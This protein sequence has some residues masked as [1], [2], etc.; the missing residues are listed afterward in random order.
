MIFLDVH[1]DAPYARV[2][3]RR[4]RAHPLRVAGTDGQQGRDEEKEEEVVVV[5]WCRR[6]EWGWGIEPLRHQL[7]PRLQLHPHAII[8]SSSRGGL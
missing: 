8:P 1:T 5:W 7:R 6:W 4:L 3:T 2:C